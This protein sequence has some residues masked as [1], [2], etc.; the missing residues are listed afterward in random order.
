[1]TSCKPLIQATSFVAFVALTT[2]HLCAISLTTFDGDPT[3]HGAI[4]VTGLSD[5]GR[6]I[7][8]ETSTTSNHPNNGNANLFQMYRYDT[9]S[10]GM[11]VIGTGY[12]DDF[13]FVSTPNSVSDD[14]KVGGI[15]ISGLGGFSPHFPSDGI[16]SIPGSGIQTMGLSNGFATR[17][18]EVTLTGSG[19]KTFAIQN[20][21]GSFEWNG[22]EAIFFNEIDPLLSG[23]QFRDTSADGSVLLVSQSTSTFYTYT[24]VNGLTQLPAGFT[25][26]GITSNGMVAH[27][28]L[29]LQGS[30]RV[31]I[32]TNT[33]GVI[34]SDFSSFFSQYQSITGATSNGAYVVGQYQTGFP[35]T[36]TPFI[37]DT[38]GHVYELITELSNQGLDLGNVTITSVSGISDDGSILAGNGLLNGTND[39]GWYVE[40]FNPSLIGIP[41]PAIAGMGFAVMALIAIYRRR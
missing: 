11:A 23:L 14:G 40:G 20:G 33:T 34:E 36:S 17:I 16:I 26:S 28:N 9:L 35:S 25:P 18:S 39:I 31:A 19:N 7:I 41:E 5:N 38:D 30:N 3:G 10:D 1:M 32:W 12:E 13:A 6:Y 29:P 22:S 37:W 21:I 2:Q 15:A 8:G 24:S 4:T 27:G